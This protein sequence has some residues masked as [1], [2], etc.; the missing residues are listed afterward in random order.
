VTSSFFAWTYDQVI[1]IPALIEVAV[2]LK[3]TEQPWYRSRAVLG[4]LI[5]NVV[6]AAM[7]F[8]YAEEFHYVWLAP[9]L[10]LCY[11]LYRVDKKSPTPAIAGGG[12]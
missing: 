11:L 1:L 10:L 2:W 6:H 5:V 3:G 4:Y 9:A 7:R 12:S 8:W